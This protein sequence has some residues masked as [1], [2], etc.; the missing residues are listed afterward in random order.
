MISVVDYGVA[1]LGSMSNMLRRIGAET[2]LVT[3]AA[4][5]ARASKIILPGIGAFDHGMDALDNLGLIEELRRRVLEDG[6][7]LFGVCLGVQLLGESSAE[8][9]RSGLGLIAAHSERLPADGRAGIR[10]PHMSW[11]HIEPTRTDPILAGLDEKA[12]FYFVHSYHVVCS[13]PND[14]LAFARY[15]IPFTAMIRRNNIYG[16][17]FH[18]EKSHRFGMRLLKNFVEL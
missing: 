3:S 7:P 9:K 4:G 15:G 17:Q 12:R 8:G 14:V 5:I 11:A 10:V 6:V 16:A 1:N 13:D 2:E 18:P